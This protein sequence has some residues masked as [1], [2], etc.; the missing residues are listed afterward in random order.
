MEIE[1]H[2]RR[3]R[4]ASPP[5]HLRRT[6]LAAA[7]PWRPWYLAVAAGVLLACSA[8][9]ALSEA[10]LHRLLASRGKTEPQASPASRMTDSFLVSVPP[11]IGADSLI[12]LQRAME[13]DRQ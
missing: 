3:F 6:V 9:N 11:S 2:L 7:R 1:D 8:V 10:R 12:S 4:L 5:G 13:V